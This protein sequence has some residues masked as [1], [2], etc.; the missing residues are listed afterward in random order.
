AK[1]AAVGS[2]SPSRRAGSPSATSSEETVRPAPPAT[3]PAVHTVTGASSRP[4]SRRAGAR[5][6][7][8]GANGGSAPPRVGSPPPVLDPGSM[9]AIVLASRRRDGAGGRNLQ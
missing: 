8:G 5:R 1:N 4:R 2:I 9:A 7:A 3:S 6:P